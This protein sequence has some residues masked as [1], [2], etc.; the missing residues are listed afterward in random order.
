MCHWTL[1]PYKWMIHVTLPCIVFHVL[2]SKFIKFSETYLMDFK[3][4][5]KVFTRLLPCMCCYLSSFQVLLQYVKRSYHFIISRNCIFSLR[6]WL[7][8]MVSFGFYYAVIFFLVHCIIS[9][10]F[11]KAHNLYCTMLTTLIRIHGFDFY[12]LF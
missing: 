8:S 2:C 9:N 5:P 10:E 12:F 1:L 6:F 4:L 11:T 7:E 3:F